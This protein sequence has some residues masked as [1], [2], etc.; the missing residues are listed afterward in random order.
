[1][2]A[3]KG[4][5]RYAFQATRGKE[6]IS[7]PRC[8]VCTQRDLVRA[9]SA[10]CAQRDGLV[11]AS[12]IVNMGV[13]DQQDVTEGEESV[14]CFHLNLDSNLKNFPLDEQV[15]LIIFGLL[16]KK[17]FSIVPELHVQIHSFS[18]DLH[19]HLEDRKKRSK[20][21]DTCKKA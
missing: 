9:T 5:L 13:S 8:Q 12:C 20:A 15:Y 1:M 7:W 10:V 18:I 4:S 14:V 11:T 6:E 21:G 17:G 3:F 2:L 19:I 16:H